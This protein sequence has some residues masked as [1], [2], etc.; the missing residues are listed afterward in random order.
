MAIQ[1]G[2]TQV[3]SN[4]QGLTNIA[5]VDSTTAASITSAGVG[6]GWSQHATGTLSGATPEISIPNADFVRIYF[7]NWKKTGSVTDDVM[8][9]RKVGSS[10]VDS[11]FNYSEAFIITNTGQISDTNTTALTLQSSTS[12]YGNTGMLTL[13]FPRA[14]RSVFGEWK[15]MLDHGAAYAFNTWFLHRSTTGIDRL[16]IF[17]FSTPT[18]SGNYEVWT[19]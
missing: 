12:G 15:N 10:S 6:G 7:I 14:T 11:G 2:G 5:S 17:N 13:H 8:R 18:Y 16:R 4:T 1:V 19:A 3:I 9:F